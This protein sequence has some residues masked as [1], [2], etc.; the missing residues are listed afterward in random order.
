[1]NDIV[2]HCAHDALA[3]ITTL[4][5]NP[6]NPNRHPDKQI[7]LLGKII[8]NQGWRA[9]ITVSTRS[10]FIVRGHGRLLAAQKLGLSEVPVDRQ[11][12][13]SEAEEWADMIADNRIAELS[14]IDDEAVSRLLTEFDMDF[15][16]ELTGFSVKDID[17]LVAQFEDK[18]VVDDGFDVDQTIAGIVD[19][20]TKAG[21]IIQLGRHRLM[22]GDST[23]SAVLQKLMDG[24]MA[25]AIFTDP[26]YNVDYTGGTEEALKIANDNMSGEDFRAFLLAAF[27]AAASVT[28]AGGAIYVCHADTE[29][30]NFRTALVEAGFLLKQ[31]IV[32]VKQHFVM[33]R[34]DYHWQHEPILY[35][36]KDGAA[37]SWYGDRKQTTVWNVDRPVASP[38]H[39]T[40]KP[41]ALVGIALGNST[42]K[43]DLILD[44]FCGS[45]STVIA[46]EQ[47]ERVC[48]AVE[49]DPRYCDVI[50]K[51]WDGFAGET[52]RIGI[53]ESLCGRRRQRNMT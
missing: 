24:R 33:G 11:D 4:V 14:E 44:P 1:M 27:K 47:L 53:N 22:C 9:P 5:P 17:K 12:Y 35:G 45:G 18:D 46:A 50:V 34:Q 37:H 42:K 31:C 6:R 40:M 23:D 13:A 19:P 21:D 3:D 25:D 49:L 36:W 39:P 2:I 26:P 8:K 51:R 16:R 48:Y 7:E 29:S 30:L 20:V 32:W 15:D 38:E 43:D 28:K 52:A 41:V 10:G